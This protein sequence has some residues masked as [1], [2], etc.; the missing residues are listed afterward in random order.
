[1]YAAE[2]TARADAAVVQR[3]A[4]RSGRRA[5]T[6]DWLTLQVLTGAQ[7]GNRTGVGRTRP[8]CQWGAKVLPVDGLTRSTGIAV[9]RTVL[10][11]LLL[12]R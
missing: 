1:M 2:S 5:A 4:V 12:A 10:R 7:H 11:P 6:V 9:G 8:R 3:D